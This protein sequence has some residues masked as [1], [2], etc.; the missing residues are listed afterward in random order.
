MHMCVYILHT[1]IYIY[2]LHTYI[3]YTHTHTHTH[4]H[5]YIYIEE[6][7]G[8]LDACTHARR[9]AHLYTRTSVSYSHTCVLGQHIRPSTS[10][11]SCPRPA[12]FL[13]LISVSSLP[14][15]CSRILSLPVRWHPVAGPHGPFV[16]ADLVPGV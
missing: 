2:I 7:R 13:W 15:F 10:C 4:T 1:H 3:K 12:V 16:S 6:Y 11:I 9:L 14:R 5:I 8:I